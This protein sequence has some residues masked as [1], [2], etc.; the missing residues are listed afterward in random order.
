[1]K[2]LFRLILC[3]IFITSLNYKSSAQCVVIN[4]VLI[5]GPGS[6]DG[7]CNPD[8]E[9]WIELYNTC[10]SPVDISCFV[11][12]DGE[13]TITIPEGATIPANGYYVIGSNGSIGTGTVNLNISTCNCTSGMKIGTLTNPNDQLVLADKDGN[14]QNGIIWGGGQNL[15][16]SIKAKPSSGS[17]PQTTVAATA[18]STFFE[19]LPTNGS[20]GCTVAR[21]CDGSSLW[22]ER[23]STAITMGTS[24]GV[25]PVVDFS[26]SKTAICKG[27]C[28]SF[29]N[30]TTGAVTWNWTFSGSDSASSVLE[31]PSGI[32]YNQNGDFDVT[33][34]ITSACGNASL[35]KPAYIKV[36]GSGVIPV[37]T[38]VRDTICEG[39]PASL[40]VVDSL[41]V[42]QW[43]SSLSPDNFSDITGEQKKNLF[44][45]PSQSTFYRI[46]STTNGTC[47]DTSA[48]YQIIVNP[49]PVAAYSFTPT[50]ANGAEL[51]FNSSASI[52]ATIYDWDFGDGSRSPDMNP[53]HTFAK[54]T[55]YHVCLTT[56]N[57]SNC[58]F[59]VCK[60]IEI[61]FTGIVSI[62]ALTDGVKIY[63]NP[64][65]RFFILES[66][67]N[68]DQ[69]EI[70]DV[71]GRK[72]V[73][74]SNSNKSSNR[75]KIE[76]PHLAQGIYY[77]KIK[78][79]DT[80]IVSTLVKW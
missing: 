4:E 45:L 70:L 15:P 78:Y 24:N 22:E 41:G 35:T 31:N 43:Q 5:N 80:E 9:E 13:F 62:S 39:T 8:T 79:A 64:F 49:S 77:L 42:L 16:W 74:I 27:E 71:L 36:G 34:A 53:V 52:G 63:P 54:D 60:D 12:A 67:K 1:M 58:S 50:G 55:I 14:V 66:D 33:L 17:C 59:T 47:T 10:S 72:Q 2:P 11:I 48:P 26:V 37:I 19:V 38:A 46:Y 25:K 44:S 30:T 21:S 7:S 69:V 23:C 76:T 40:S 20:N 29:T 51:S 3:G 56:Y 32:C 61:S 18:T 68:I 65:E 73:N 28:L 6:C 75:I 57:G